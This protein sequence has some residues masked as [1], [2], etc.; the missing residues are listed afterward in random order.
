MPKAGF[1]RA[2][3]L[4]LVSKNTALLHADTWLNLPRNANARQQLLTVVRD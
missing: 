2:Y 4:G 3:E 1:F